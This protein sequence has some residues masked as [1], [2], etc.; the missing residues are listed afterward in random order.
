MKMVLIVFLLSVGICAAQ[1]QTSNAAFDGSGTAVSSFPASALNVT[2]T[3]GEPIVIAAAWNGTGTATPSDTS[4]ATIISKVGPFNPAGSNHMQ[5]W[6]V[7][8]ASA[9]THG[10]QVSLTGGT[11]TFPFLWVMAPS[12]GDTT[13][14]CDGG[15]T[16]G[17]NSA[18]LA[19]SGWTATNPGE[20]VIAFGTSFGGGT[21]SAGTSPITFTADSHSPGCNCLAEYGALV[22]S[23]A[24]SA[25]FSDS[26]SETW[27][28][29][30]VSIKL[31][32]HLPVPRHHVGW[33]AG[34]LGFGPSQ[35]AHGQ[36]IIWEDDCSSD[37]CAP[38]LATAARLQS[39]GE[40]T[41]LAV[42][43][44]TSNDY[45]E[46]ALFGYLKYYKLSTVPIGAFK[47]TSGDNTSAYTQTIS[48]TF[49]KG[50][51]DTRANYTDCV[52]VYR[53]ALADATYRSVALVETGIP[54][55]TVGLLNS[56][57]DSISPLTGAQLIQ[58]KVKLLS[59]MGGKYP[60]SSGTAEFN[61]SQDSA[62]MH[63]LVTTW[64]TQNGYPPIYFTGFD[65]GTGVL[66]GP[67][68][69]P[70]DTVNP[71]LKEYHLL[72]LASREQWDALAMLFA[73]R[74]LSFGGTTYFTDNG[75]GTMSVDASSGNDTW[76][77]TPS[78]G[79]H[80]LTNADSTADLSSVFNGFL[81]E[82]P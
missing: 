14:P 27:G 31:G 9:G 76:S 7:A 2:V 39:R 15:N 18:S 1:I 57:A 61:F 6:C 37:I 70:P 32:T 68:S 69:S 29:I 80:Y 49:G 16:G 74:G 40:A 72:G 20:L 33:D 51:G 75:D 79:H 60:T 21:M 11:T 45:S 52:T 44:S 58:Q 71:V 10:F 59:I 22:G 24:A 30:G 28:A 8:N 78:S 64:T 73:V 63:T 67:P 41:L 13:S 47:G 19:T 43:G 3:G 23:A 17:G 50:P 12:S 36:F 65:S 56:P 38:T 34:I 55:C 66:A 48:D 82:I 46:G 54:T 42:A 4:G 25:S 5:L 62:D 53:T 35:P 77:A 26:A 81:A